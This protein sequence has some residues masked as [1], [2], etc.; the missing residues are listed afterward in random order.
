MARRRMI[1]PNFWQSE[2]VSKLSLTQRLLLI[3]LFSNADDE[4][5]LRGKPAFV[6]S[7]IFPYDD[8]SIADVEEALNQIESIGTIIQ[9]EV[10]G[11]QY[12]KLINWEKFQRVDKPQPSLIPDPVEEKEQESN[13]N[14]A[15]NSSKNESMNESKNDSDDQNEH[16]STDSC[17][18]EKKLKEVKRKEVS[19][20]D[21]N[22]SFQELIKELKTMLKDFTEA[23][24]P[25][26]QLYLNQGMEREVITLAFERTLMQATA[27]TVK[28]AKRILN[29]W[30][31]KGLLTKEKIEEE[32]PPKGSERAAPSPQQPSTYDLKVE[33]QDVWL[34]HKGDPN[35]A[36]GI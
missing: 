19:T 36:P 2:D 15:K 4:G 17:L 28:Y 13:K 31:Y 12:I 29:D 32:D 8:I 6:R 34:N 25:A 22:E 18:K 20:D 16:T 30:F 10:S 27:P 24:E 5:K 23:D 35:A 3:G 9:Y 11:S 1:D 7:I 26:I 33:A 14:K 21:S